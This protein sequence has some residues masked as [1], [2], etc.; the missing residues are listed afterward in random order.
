MITEVLR[1]ESHALKSL[2][3]SLYVCLMYS[4]TGGNH[5]GTVALWAALLRCR[6]HFDQNP[7]TV[8]L[9]STK[10]LGKDSP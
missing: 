7:L 3:L 1:R 9:H 5:R 6:A 10:K 2:S 4:R 8:S